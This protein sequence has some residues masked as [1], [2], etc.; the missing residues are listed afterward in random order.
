MRPLIGATPG[1]AGPS[2]ARNFCRTAE[3]VYSDLNYLRRLEEAGGIPLLLSH[4]DDPEMMRELADELDGLMLTGGEDIHPNHYGQEVHNGTEVNAARDQFELHLLDAFL[5]TGKP[6]LAIC[7]GFQV[8]NVALGGT[9]IQD[10]ATQAGIFHHVQRAPTATPTHEVRLDERC[11][12]AGIYGVTQLEVN[13]HH[14]QAV[15]RPAPDLVVVGWS[16]EGIPEA[17]EHRE[18][19]YLLGVQWHPER[20]ASRYE[21]QEKLFVDFVNACKRNGLPKTE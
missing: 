13:S 2:E 14:H 4:T 17:F 11:R 19:P 16:E 10:L 21:M 15:D 9:L 7:R 8:V 20:L 6:I 18:H 3:I 12:L 5:K 1:Y